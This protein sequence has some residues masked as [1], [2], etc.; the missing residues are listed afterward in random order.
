MCGYVGM[1]IFH[2]CFRVSGV[3]VFVRTQT[4]GRVSLSVYACVRLCFCVCLCL[5]VCFYVCVF[6]FQKCIYVSILMGGY[7]CNL[8]LGSVCVSVWVCGCA[9]VRLV[10]LCV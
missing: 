1:F 5:C 4:V 7:V 6:A 8:P 9:C 10:W 2:A 3:R